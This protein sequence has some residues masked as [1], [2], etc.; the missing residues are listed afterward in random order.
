MSEAFD[1]AVAIVL[2]Q[3]DSTGTGVVTNDPA[4]PGGETRWGIS[5]RF[6]DQAGLPFR[7]R[8]LFREQAIAIYHEAFWNEY[9]FELLPEPIAVK[10]FSFL[11]N[12]GPDPAFRIL[13]RALRACLVEVEED[14]VLGPLTRAAVGRAPSTD[15]LLAALRSEMAGFYRDLDRPRFERG[16]LNRAYSA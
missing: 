3:E 6:L 5:Q 1:R 14:G 11:V 4:D 9:R 13:Q 12:A 10:L 8:D 16:W 7:A 2:Q 15:C